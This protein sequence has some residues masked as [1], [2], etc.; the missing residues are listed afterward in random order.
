MPYNADVSDV[1]VSGSSYVK[2]DGRAIMQAQIANP[3]GYV[4]LN[5]PFIKGYTPTE[6]YNHMDTRLNRPRYY[7]STP[8]G[9]AY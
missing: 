8:S 7:Y 6:F 4:S 9:L 2:R 5:P 1:V 3:L